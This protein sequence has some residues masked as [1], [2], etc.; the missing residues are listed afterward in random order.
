M[1]VLP[2]GRALG[3]K[4][5]EVKTRTN[6]TTHIIF[7]VGTMFKKHSQEFG[8]LGA[9][10]TRAIGPANASLGKSSQNCIRGKIV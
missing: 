4:S 8:G 10:G 5:D 7:L 6:T 9:C 1:I 3:V 2:L